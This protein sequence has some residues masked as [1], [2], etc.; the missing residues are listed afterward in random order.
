MPV[1]MSGNVGDI[2]RIT[3]K[4]S[5]GVLSKLV[6]ITLFSIYFG[7]EA[8]L[9]GYT[10]VGLAG[11]KAIK[12]LDAFDYK[13]LRNSLTYLKRKGF[14]QS[15]REGILLPKI[16]DEGKKKLESIIPEYDSKRY[17]DKRLYLIVY[18]L[19]RNKNI[20]RDLLRS[21]LRKIGCGYV[22][23]SVWLT[24]YNP[25]TLIG[26]FLNLH[27]LDEEMVIIS[28]IGKDGTIGNTD[29][30]SLVAKVYDLFELNDRY[31]VF[32]NNVRNNTFSN[33]SQLI[34]S[35]LSILEDDPQIPFELLPN[36]W[37]GDEAYKLYKT[38]I[39]V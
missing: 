32:I 24:P 6:D 25:K 19:P 16:T 7:T 34:F 1:K 10:K 12:D 4:I 26:E 14:I 33:K 18:D 36:D 2:S 5:E 22:Q 20:Q 21:Y 3:R 30:K 13:S 28:S 39:K 37:V 17:W 23:H 11:N 29:L 35:L 8:S 31:T 38:F 9:S 15:A 27:A